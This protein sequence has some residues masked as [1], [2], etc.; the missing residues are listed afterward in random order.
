MRFQPHR[1]EHPCV[2]HRVDRWCGPYGV[3]ELICGA[4]RIDSVVVGFESSSVAT[5]QRHCPL[6]LEDGID[7]HPFIPFSAMQSSMF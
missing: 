4:C 7:R 6:E 5:G 3:G 1:L 2:V